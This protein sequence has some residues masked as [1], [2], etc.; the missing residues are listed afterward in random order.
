MLAAVLPL[1][2]S[3]APHAPANVVLILA[4]DLGAHDLGFTGS[5]FHETPHLDRLA[6]ESM[7]FTQAYS[8]CTVCSPT[9]AALMTGK[10]PARLKITDWIAGHDFPKAKLRPPEWTKHLPL[11]ETT[12][13]EHLKSAGYATLHIGKWHLGGEGFGPEQQGFD[14]NLG[15]DRGG[16]P[17]SY[18]AP[19]RLPNLPDSPAGEYLT[20]REGEEAARFIAANK[21]RPFFLNAAFHAVHTPL[22]AKPELIEKYR[23]KVRGV[24]GAQTNAVYAAM[25][26]SLDAAVGRILRALEEAGVADR[27][28]MIFTSDNGGLVLGAPTSNAPLRSGKGSPYEG[29]VRVPLLIRWPGVTKPG[30]TSAVPVISMDLPATVLDLARS[31]RRESAQPSRPK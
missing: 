11:E 31:S 8:A 17:M 19:Y 7:R 14:A 28:A 12:L 1:A 26:E 18:F 6:R 23:R 20:D 5:R 16:Q 9:R 3:A 2:L 25:L 13:A 4:D 10:Y 21:G 22:Q 24:G 27:T 30:S 29:G 15:G